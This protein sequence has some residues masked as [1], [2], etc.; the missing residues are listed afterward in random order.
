MKTKEQ[1]DKQFK[2]NER[3]NQLEKAEKITTSI[4]L[5]VVIKSN[6][7]ITKQTIKMIESFYNNKEE[8]YIKLDHKVDFFNKGKEVIGINTTG[9]SAE[10]SIEEEKGENYEK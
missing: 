10:W 8:P 9:V 3:M 7:K 5:N 4:K 6:F 2:I 1:R